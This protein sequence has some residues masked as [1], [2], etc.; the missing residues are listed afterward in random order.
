MSSDAPGTPAAR[1]R[2]AARWAKAAAGPTGRSAAR[3]A[4]AAAGP[5]EA[6]SERAIV[7]REAL[8]DVLMLVPLVVI[9]VLVDVV[10]RWLGPTGF[11]ATATDVL[12]WACL[13]AT[14]GTYARYVVLGWLR[15][16]DRQSA[17][18]GK[19]S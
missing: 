2:R 18:R 19:R 7:V 4:K 10:L 3:W 12:Q 15:A 17:E 14:V 6:I 1:G 13:V 16:G 8:F 5:T 9:N 11:S